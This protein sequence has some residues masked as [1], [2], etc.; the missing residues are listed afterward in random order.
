MIQHDFTHDGRPIR[1]EIYNFRTSI[2]PHSRNVLAAQALA[3][4]ADYILWIDSDMSFPGDSLERLMAWRK[5]IVS[6]NCVRRGVPP[7]YTATRYTDSGPQP[8]PT[9][10]GATGVVAVD[11]VGFGVMLVNADVFRR[12]PQP[13]FTGAFEIDSNRQ[14]W[15]EDQL[16]CQAATAQGYSVYIDQGLSHEI[17]HWGTCGYGLH[18]MQSPIVGTS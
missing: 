16:F 11:G 9:E 3:A 15:G 2:L 14:A 5:D 10:P 12:L 17:R 6:V 18:D 4:S 7:T 8:I 1:L 13:W